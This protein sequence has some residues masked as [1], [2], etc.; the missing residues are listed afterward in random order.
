M[1]KNI[2]LENK[3][4]LFKIYLQLIIK[5]YVRKIKLIIYNM[6]FN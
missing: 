3:P 4:K 5:N 2:N 1:N 6:N